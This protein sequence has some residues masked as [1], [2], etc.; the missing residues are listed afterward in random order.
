MNVIISTR[1]EVKYLIHTVFFKLE[2][3]VYFNSYFHAESVVDIQ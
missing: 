1:L 3:V 2:T